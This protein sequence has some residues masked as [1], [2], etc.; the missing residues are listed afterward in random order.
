MRLWTKVYIRLK[1]KAWTDF[2]LKKCMKLRLS[3]DMNM[4]VFFLIFYCID[5]LAD[6][7]VLTAVISKM[8]KFLSVSFFSN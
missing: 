5:D 7:R 6:R 4:I 8:Q 1:E 3:F 2:N